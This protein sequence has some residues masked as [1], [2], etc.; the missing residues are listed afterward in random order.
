MIKIKV[1]DIKPNMM[2]ASDV[3][4]LHKITL[5]IKKGTVIDKHLI[6]LLK[7]HKI[8]YVYI[9]DKHF[10][11]N[12]SIK[13][14]DNKKEKEAVLSNIDNALSGFARKIYRQIYL[15]LN[16]I[17]KHRRVKPFLKE[18]TEIADEFVHKIDLQLLTGIYDLN[19]ISN[20][21]LLHSIKT[22]ILSVYLG[23]INLLNNKDLRDIT[24]SSILCNIGYKDIPKNILLSKGLLSREEKTIVEMHP[25]HGYR[26]IVEE[27]I[28]GNTALA[29]LQHHERIDGSG[30]PSK[31]KNIH[32]WS[33]IIAIAD[34]YSAL[35]S[36]RIYRPA[37]ARYK[38]LEIMMGD[39]AKYDRELLTIFISIFAF[40]PIGM[41]VNLSDGSTGI[42][43]GTHIG[44]PFRPIV[45]VGDEIVDLSKNLTLFITN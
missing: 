37:Y 6:G 31:T 25:L 36:K 40:Y 8:P 22:M 4:C 28:S 7:K 41:E 24:L 15:A 9:V 42:I 2:I 30:Y 19:I 38:A 26:R 3:L 18:F 11:Y 16:D 33:R 35:T 10:I 23:K 21:F 34:V 1:E 44:L 39:S 43:V 27:G 5:L 45:K 20:E 29:V 32:R 13:Y 17:F 12:K 14:F